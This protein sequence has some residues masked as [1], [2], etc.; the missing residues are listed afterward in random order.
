[1]KEK[2]K[3]RNTTEDV[4][5]NPLVTLGIAMS[6]GTSGMIENQEAAE[7]SD[8][9]NSTTLPTKSMTTDAKQILEKFGVIFGEV[10]E[11]DPMFQYIALPDGWTKE[12]TDHNMHSQVLDDKGRK[13]ISVFYKAGFYARSA[14]FTVSRRYGCTYD[15]EH[16]KET[17]MFVGIATDCDDVIY[18]SEPLPDKTEAGESQLNNYAKCQIVAKAWLGENYPDWDDPSAYWG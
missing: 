13:R 14:H 12:G 2:R 9:V 6:E 3:V 11:G 18:R 1:M 17:G 10:V 5:S 16:W 8:F 15:Y 4:K 7:Q